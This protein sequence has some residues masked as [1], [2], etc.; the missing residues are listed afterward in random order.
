MESKD[1]LNC[2]YKPLK[3]IKLHV[4]AFMVES[5]KGFSSNE[6]RN[7]KLQALRV[8][9]FRVL[10]NESQKM[11]VSIEEVI[12]QFQKEI[13]D[14]QKNYMTKYR[15]KAEYYYIDKILSELAGYNIPKENEE[16]ER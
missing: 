4:E 9:I 12:A 11:G 8:S 14:E 7:E 10:E 1:V 2:E 15:Y 13:Q 3:L 16:N 6:E 5:E